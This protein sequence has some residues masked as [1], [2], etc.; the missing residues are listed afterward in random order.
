MKNYR[1][2]TLS[3]I[4]VKIIIQICDFGLTSIIHVFVDINL[5]LHEGPN[6]GSKLSCQFFL[7]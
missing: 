7:I 2:I 5:G 1:F 6:Q 4:F 3:S